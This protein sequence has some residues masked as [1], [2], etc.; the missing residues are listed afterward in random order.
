M[1]ET[2]HFT[3]ADKYTYA[4]DYIPAKHFQPTVLLVH[5]FPSSRR[6]WNAQ[7]ASLSAVGFG[8]IAPDNLGYGD[9]SKPRDVNAYK[10][11]H[12]TAHLDALLR[13]EG[14]DTV[15]GVGHDWGVNILSAFT[16][17]YPHRFEKLAFLNVGYSPPAFFDVDAINALGQ[18]ENGYPPFGYWYFFD[19]YDA[20]KIITDH[21]ESFFNLVFPV[22]STLWRDNLAKVGGA[23]AWLNHDNTTALPA[24]RTEADKAAWL[25]HYHAPGAI[26]AS[27]NTYR[28]LLRGVNAKDEATVTDT[29]R[30]LKVPVLGV[31]GTLDLVAQ[32]DWVSAQIEPYAKKGYTYKALESGH[33]VM[34]E[35]SEELNT[36]LKEFAARS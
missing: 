13:H 12:L 17:W 27:L 35:K 20:A 25:K 34:L 29:Q 31:G 2:K 15:V 33:W 32:A 21:L 36:I 5:G 16:V 19:R 24:W 9:S 23:R 14:L 1:A 26:S 10:L 28:S 11:R 8:V 18:Q 22:N 30:M 3:T 6:D 4:Y 7:I